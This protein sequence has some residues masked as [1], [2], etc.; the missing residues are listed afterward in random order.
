MP[1]STTLTTPALTEAAASEALSPTVGLFYRTTAHL[2]ARWL[3]HRGVADVVLA[4]ILLVLAV[5]ALA[6]SR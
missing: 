3:N 2:R 5:A 6:A 4:A 1:A